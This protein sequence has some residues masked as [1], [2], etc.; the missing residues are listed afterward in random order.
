VE[1][2]NGQ[3]S[4]PF[5]GFVYTREPEIE[6]F[7]P[8]NGKPQGGTRVTI[9]GR[10]FMKDITVTFDKN[11]AEAVKWLSYTTIE[12]FTPLLAVEHPTPVDVAVTNV[13]GQ[14]GKSDDDF[15]YTEAPHIDRISP[16]S[17]TPKGG[18]PITISGRWFID[19]SSV[20]IGE[21][22][23]SEVKVKSDTEITAFTPSGLLGKK[24]VIVINPYS[25]AGTLPG[26]F[27]YKEAPVIQGIYPVV[28][29]LAGNTQLTINGSGFVEG[30]IVKIGEKPAL[31][32]EFASETHL[33]AITPPSEDAG[34][35]NV[36]VI[37]PDGQQS[38]SA[39]F[40]Y[41]DFPGEIRIYNFPNPFQ[42]GQNTTF[43]YKGGNGKKV[44][45]KIFN[46]AGELVQSLSKEGGETINWDG[47]DL[48]EDKVPP[49]LYP[50]IYLLNGKFEQRQLLQIIE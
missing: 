6:K 1:N 39:K 46:L 28:G 12:V 10:W 4:N 8:V 40:N 38:A 14:S 47:R 7:Y 49:G 21:T 26:G 41:V 5:V 27:E 25:Q 15:I 11:P 17:G 48:E 18:T 36:I 32:V 19:G 3:S 34:L 22:E 31:S 50:Y 29:P 23:A 45:I 33:T 30:A 44:E 16:I 13:Y 20:K 35:K 24:D 2:P 9:T 37:N 43:R 42:T